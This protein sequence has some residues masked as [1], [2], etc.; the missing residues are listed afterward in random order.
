MDIP[1]N[2]DETCGTRTLLTCRTLVGA[3]LLEWTVLREAVRIVDYR[4]IA[5]VEVDDLAMRQVRALAVTISH[6]TWLSV[7]VEGGITVGL[8]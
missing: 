2:F 4:D 5:V 6:G 3:P 1:L 8:G 7:E